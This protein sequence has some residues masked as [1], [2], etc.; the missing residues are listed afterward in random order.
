[1]RRGDPEVSFPVLVQ[2]PDGVIRQP[3]GRGECRELPVL[4]PGQSAAL[5]ANPQRPVVVLQQAANF[6]VLQ[7][8]VLDA[9]SGEVDTVKTHQPSAVPS[10]R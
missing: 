3:I 5:G 4:I 1:M 6:V 2:S 8:A 7:T 10:Q 9:K